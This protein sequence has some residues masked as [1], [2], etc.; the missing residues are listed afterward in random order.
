MVS[1]IVLVPVANGIEEI[2]V[3][4][5]I[6]VLRRAGIWFASAVLKIEKLRLL[7]ASR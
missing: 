4:A 1:K 3:V 5:V 6:D 7:M 2:E